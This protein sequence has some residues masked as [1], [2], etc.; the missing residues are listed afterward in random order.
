M[1]I[2]NINHNLACEKMN[3]YG[4]G[5][6]WTITINDMYSNGQK[7]LLFSVPIL[8]TEMDDIN[9]LMKSTIN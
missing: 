5:W 7:K 8:P 1:G 9:T 2:N 4:I 3:L 6:N